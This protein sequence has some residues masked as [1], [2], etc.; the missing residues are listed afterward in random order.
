MSKSAV[1]LFSL[2]PN[3][4]ETKRIKGHGKHGK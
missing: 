1:F 2:L 3:N 4:A